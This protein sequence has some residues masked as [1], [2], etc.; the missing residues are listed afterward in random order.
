MPQSITIASGKGGVGKT[1]IAVNLSLTLASMGLRVKLL[2]ADFGLANSHVLMG[3]N[4]TRS[5]RD[6]ISGERTLEEVAERVAPGLDLYAGGS[7]L[8]DLLNVDPTVRY[9]LIRN[10]DPLAAET[11]VLLIDAPAGASDNALSFVAASDRVLVVI[12]PE[13][14]SFMDAYALIKAANIDYGLERFSIVV[15]MAANEAEA[16]RHFEKFRAITMRFL[17]VELTHVGHVPLSN[18]LSRSIVALKPIMLGG[19]NPSTPEGAA[20]R[21]LANGVLHAPVNATR[22]LRFFD[23]AGGIAALP[24]IA[25]PPR[26]EAGGAGGMAAPAPG[27][28]ESVTG[29]LVRLHD[30]L[31]GLRQS[32]AT[33][34]TAAAAAIET[35]RI[36]SAGFDPVL[37][38]DLARIDT[39]AAP[40]PAFARALAA[41]IVEDDPDARLGAD[42]VWILGPSGAGRTSLAAK[43]GAHAARLRPDRAVAVMSI[44]ARG[45]VDDGRLRLLAATLGP[46]TA[47]ATWAEDTPPPSFEPGVTHI[48]DM[49]A[50]P[51]V[52]ARL[53]AALA[54]ALGDRAQAGILVLPGGAS[55]TLIARQLD[56]PEAAGAVVAL[57]KLD[58]CPAAPG[59]LLALAQ[60]GA[61]VGWLSAGA[62]PGSDLRAVTT[63]IMHDHIAGAT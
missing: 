43:L 25:T 18:A 56:R 11:D 12:V 15:N 8:S 63:T 30:A 57:S 13:P 6:V 1:C 45:A 20:F 33:E 48:L 54:P 34:P 2:D 50:Q 29:I 37:A 44:L 59:E 17:S 55:A 3:I 62:A 39:G 4:S 52:V 14:T 60:R 40:A 7:A 61:R 41:Q 53:H 36:L 31:A 26:P 49:P 28:N 32:M 42:V 23:D 9:R 22:G 10:F 19:G 38:R 16:A 24:R 35:N 58:E 51:E 21:K 5:I 47:F 27:G 46:G